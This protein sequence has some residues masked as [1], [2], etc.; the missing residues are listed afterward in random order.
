[1]VPPLSAVKTVADLA[2][3]AAAG[4]V[5]KTVGDLK[6]AADSYEDADVMNSQTINQI[7][8]LMGGQ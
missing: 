3:D 8:A 5:E 2:I 1:M 7:T 4:A 6:Q